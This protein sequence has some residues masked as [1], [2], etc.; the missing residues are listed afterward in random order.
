MRITAYAH[1]TRGDVWPMIAL[2]TELSQ[3][4][5]EV[6]LAVSAEFRGLVEQC[7]LEFSPLPVDLVDYL[8]SD[9]GQRLVHTGGVALMRR[10]QQLLA[11]HAD[12][13]DEGFIASATG[14]DAVI[15]N[16]MTFERAQCVADA[17]A[18]PVALVWPLSAAVTG[19]FGSQIVTRGR[20]RSRTLRKLSHEVAWRI[21][22]HASAGQIRAFRRKLGLSPRSAPAFQR[23]SNPHALWL[24]TFSPSLLPRPSDWPS[25]LKVTGAWQAPPRLRSAASESVPKELETWLEDGDPPIFF[26]FGSMPV[27]EPQRLLDDAIAVSEALGARAIVNA[28]WAQ[29]GRV[30]AP[31]SDRFRIV[32]A[33]DHD[34]LLPRCRAAVHHGGAGTTTAAA[35]AGCP[36]LVCSVWADQPWWGEHLAR[37][38]VGAHIRFRKLDRESLLRGLNEV[39]D[40]R[41][42][43]RAQALGAAIRAEGDGLRAAT[44][45]LD[46]WLATAQPT[47]TG[48]RRRT[49]RAEVLPRGKRT[50][51]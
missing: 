37:R 9:D 36:A 34:R 14:A 21:W 8:A 25:Y 35:R 30:D 6:T 48:V 26:G 23:L 2:G 20:I 13:M 29:R 38:G 46:Q 24:H 32:G 3:R 11:G 10:L 27:F 50:R 12:A 41:V 5:H 39:L 19:E 43:G 45:L 17:R 7:G 1:G 18:I 31:I 49:T 15:A 22:W 42:R 51:T 4:G 33:V 47:P 40:P 44:D 28:D 16:H